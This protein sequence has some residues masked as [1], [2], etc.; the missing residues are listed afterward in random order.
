MKL[1]GNTILITGGGSGIGF[2]L[3]ERFL[4]LNNEVIIVGRREDKLQEAKSKYPELHTRTCDVSKES[5]RISLFNW[6]SKE[7]PNLNFLV[8]NAGIQQRVN[9]LNAT[10]DWNYYSDEIAINL[11]GPIHLS[12]LFIPE[13]VKRDNSSIINIS[14]GLSITPGVWVPIYSATKAALHSFTVSLRLQLAKTN[15][16]VIEVFPPAVNTDLG[17]AGLHTFGV[18][19]NDLA[20]SVFKGLENENL[21]IGY[22]GTEKRLSASMDEIRQGTKAAW[23][24]FLSR[25]PKF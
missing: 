14:S 2:A 10:E 17:G 1:S 16:N 4:K 22:G 25:T 11:E 13:L 15:V 12:M 18:D 21:E 6:V 7:F 20:D 8:N 19:V 5:D 23:E 9:L 3:A 24:S